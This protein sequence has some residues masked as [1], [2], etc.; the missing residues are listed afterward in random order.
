[1]AQLNEDIQ[2]LRLGP[3]GRLVIPARV[4]KSLRLKQGDTLVYWIE[5]DRLI[6]R[7][8][9]AVE[10]ELWAQFKG[11]KSS[12]AEE[13]IVERRREAEREG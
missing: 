3:Q 2:P 12:L 9:H 1:M 7:P 8:R 5:G 13:L 4:R 11:I 6:L 10:E